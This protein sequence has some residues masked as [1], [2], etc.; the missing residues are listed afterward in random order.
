[1]YPTI[2]LSLGPLGVTGTGLA[3]TGAAVVVVIAIVI[4]LIKARPSFAVM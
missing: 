1:M 2:E 4:W 3:G